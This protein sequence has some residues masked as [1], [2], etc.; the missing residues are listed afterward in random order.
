MAFYPLNFKK[1][2]K[3][4]NARRDEFAQIMLSG[5]CVVKWEKLSRVGNK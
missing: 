3:K 4:S 5:Q 2:V 1:K